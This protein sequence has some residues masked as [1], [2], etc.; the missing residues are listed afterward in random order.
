MT[1]KD[2]ANVLFPNITKTVEDYKNMYPKRELKEGEK[3]TRFAPSPTGFMHLGGFYQAIIDKV[4]AHNSNGIFYLRNEDTDQKREVKEA[5]ELIMDTLNYYD[6]KPDEYEYNGNIVGNYG[7]YIQSERKEI[8]HAFIKYLIEI[9]R[10]YPCFCK[11]EELDQ[12]REKQE[13]YKA[14]IGYYG[15]YA[16]CRNLSIDEIIEKIKN[17]EE[18]VIRFKSLGDNEKRFFFDDLVRGTLSLPENDQ[19]IVIMK[20]NDKLPTY[21]FAHF[22]DDFLMGTTHVVRGEEWLPSVPV[23]VE[24]FKAF[25]AK[26]PKYIHTPLIVKKEG[27]SVRKL[28]KRKDPEATMSYYEENGYPQEAVIESL[29][30]IINSNYEEW[31]DKNPEKTYLDFTF[32]PKKM[33][34][35]G[36]A[37]YDIE[38]LNNISKNFISKLSAIEV[39][40]R[41]SIWSKKYDEKFYELITKYKDYTINILNIER[42]QKKPRKDYENYKSIKPQIWYMYDELFDKKEYNFQNI[43]D[44]NE[45]KL[46][47]NTYVEKYYDESDDKDTWFNKVKELSEELGY[48]SNMKEYKE[49]PEK[50]KGN[51]A[52]VST[53]IRVAVTT[54]SQTPDLY[55]IL[56]LL[57]KEKII[58]RINLI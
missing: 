7:P 12:M 47:L 49:N 42:V 51:V 57:G 43:T 56:K 19:D 32:S 55:E 26:P 10:A 54:S 39:Y 58:K 21:H 6:V 3:V 37:L 9:D 16:K 52:D 50:F 11:K 30:T 8:Y 20:S 25:D 33:S 36:G 18:Y 13:K 38:K 17:G 46:I 15:R 35:S 29:M 23:H 27:N 41:L 22:V 45:I 2:L 34:S 31:H 28:S 40:D 1:N 14:R 44:K 48:A 4:L 5:V 53:V 24:L